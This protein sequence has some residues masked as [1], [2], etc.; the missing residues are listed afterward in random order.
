MPMVRK[1]AYD[2]IPS[3]YCSNNSSTFQLSIIKK[4]TILLVRACNDNSNFLLQ[5]PLHLDL[6][7][8]FTWFCYLIAVVRRTLQYVLSQFFYSS[9]CCFSTIMIKQTFE[10]FSCRAYSPTTRKCLRVKNK[11]THRKIYC[12]FVNDLTVQM[13]TAAFDES[14]N[15]HSLKARL[16]SF[17][18]I[19]PNSCFWNVIRL[20]EDA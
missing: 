19:L 15:D 18:E 10:I 16:C 6:Y 4:S 17:V 9:S 2:K 7:S 20:F 11:T 5:S 3:W 8:A 1:M 13:L 12:C 14:N